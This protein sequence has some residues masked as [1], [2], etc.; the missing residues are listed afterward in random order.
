ME[1]AWFKVPVADQV[2]ES[3]VQRNA[4]GFRLRDM[5][6]GTEASPPPVVRPKAVGFKYPP[7]THLHTPPVSVRELG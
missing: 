5:G 6:T 1:A 7:V 3:Q 4:L 2:D